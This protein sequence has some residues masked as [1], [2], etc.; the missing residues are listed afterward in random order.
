MPECPGIKELGEL[1]AEI[2][3]QVREAGVKAHARVLK[4]VA[5]I[6]GVKLGDVAIPPE[7]LAPRDLFE[8]SRIGLEFEVALR[9]G[10]ASLS[11]KC[12][13]QKA[14]VTMEWKTVPAPEATSLLRV[15]AE[16]EV[17]SRVRTIE[18]SSM[19]PA[20]EETDG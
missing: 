6:E 18:W 19:T 20:K 9:D 7:A 1:L 8:A 4:E 10:S 13:G 15:H 3:A 12:I 11:K 17:D 16:A 2:D 14:K 5:R